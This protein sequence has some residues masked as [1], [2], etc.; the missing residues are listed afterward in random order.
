ML[1]RRTSSVRSSCN[2]AAEGRHITERDQDAPS[3]GQQLL[4]VPI[5]RRH[6]RFAQPE[7]VGQRPRRHLR[8]VQIGRD[9]D[10]AH[11][12]EAEQRGLIHELVEKH[13]VILDTE[14]AHTLQKAF[15]ISLALFPYEVGMRR[16]EHDIDRIGPAFQDRRHGVNDDFD[17]LVGRQQPKRQQDALVLES[18]LLPSPDPVRQTESRECRAG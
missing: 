2:L 1:C 7:T 5:R 16:A 17:A 15:A 9:V 6:H 10:V 3:I 8:L 12:D 4:G 14:F 11:R 13:H 18:E